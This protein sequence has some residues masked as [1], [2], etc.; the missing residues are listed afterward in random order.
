MP[1]VTLQAAGLMQCTCP[2]GVSCCRRGLHWRGIAVRDLVFFPMQKVRGV[3]QAM[4]AVHG[5]QQLQHS[6]GQIGGLP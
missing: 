4:A 3:V 6:V 2:A 1:C 5:S